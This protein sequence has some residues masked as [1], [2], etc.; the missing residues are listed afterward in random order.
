M[1][2]FVTG[3]IIVYAL[4]VS[5]IM[6]GLDGGLGEVLR[7]KKRKV[8]PHSTMSVGGFQ[9]VRCADTLSLL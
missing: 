4:V 6:F 3:L 7:K 8:L 9:M 5:V 1:W 2:L